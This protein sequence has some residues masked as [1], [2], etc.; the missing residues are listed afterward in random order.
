MEKS[1]IALGCSSR[2]FKE[3]K[4]VTALLDACFECGVNVFDTARGYG[5][6]EEVLGEYLRKK[7]R[8]S[9][10]LISKG[11]LPLPF[12]RL[13]PHCLKSDLATSLKTLDVGYIDLYLL[14]RDDHKANL[15]E[16]FSILEE[17]RKQGKIRAYG[18]S[19]WTSKRVAEANALCKKKGYAPITAISN[20]FTVLPWVHDPWGGGDGCVSITGKEDE[21]TYLRE[22]NI[23][24]Y[25]YSPLGRGFLT[26]R[27]KSTD[28]ESIASADKASRRAYLSDANLARLRRIE[29]IA[30][31]LSISVP[32]L[33]LSYLCHQK[34][35][36]IPVIGTLSPKRIKD[37]LIAAQRSL[38][39]EVY[40]ELRLLAR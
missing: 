12:S 4:D 11:C 14:H 7:P 27:V 21:L 30:T 18:V 26:G 28:P 37:N 8:N 1:P 35:E 15:E 17:A 34:E 23:A 29:E 6:S 38:P 22:N 20:N 13:K 32:D 25:A 5:R 10:Y 19:N 36:V 3:G 39:Q 24:I 33:V 9:Y 40:D 16:I 31:S 2:D